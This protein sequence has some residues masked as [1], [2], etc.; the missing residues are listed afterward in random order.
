[1]TDTPEQPVEKPTIVSN[2]KHWY[3]DLPDKK[4]YLEFLTALLSIPVLVTVIISNV[5]SLT[6]KQTST[7]SPPPNPTI[8]IR[9]VPVSG[10]SLS[11]VAT[12]GV[13]PVVTPTPQPTSGSA[14]CTPSVGPVQVTNPDEGQVVGSNPVSIEVDRQSTSYCAVVWSYRI[15]Q[16]PWSDYTGTSI[17]L[18]DMPP[19]PKKL[20]LRVHSVVSND[21][22]LITRNFTVAGS[23]PTPVPTT[24]TQSAG[25]AP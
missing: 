2:L 11:P 18:Y 23:S 25:L 14:Q 7:S 24:A 10:S 22:V 15:N 4:R 21:E 3:R 16:G 9:E 17:S 19:G 20:E 8:I 12:V 1:M 6:K 5:G 13:Q